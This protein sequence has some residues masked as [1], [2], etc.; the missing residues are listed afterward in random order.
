MSFN[1]NS[2]NGFTYTPYTGNYSSIEA[3]VPLISGGGKWNW[4]NKSGSFSG[5]LGLLE[6]NFNN[7]TR[8]TLFNSSHMFGFGYEFKVSISLNRA[9]NGIIE[10]ELRYRKSLGFV[11][12]PL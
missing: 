11:P 3:G 2:S 7:P 5:Q 10:N 8:V 1:W 9:M 12:R 6:Y 4:Y